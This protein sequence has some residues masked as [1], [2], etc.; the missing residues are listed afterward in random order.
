MQ[1]FIPLSMLLAPLLQGS[2]TV[3]YKEADAR[4]LKLFI[5]KPADWKPS[6]K[7]PAI[8]FYFGGGWVT[9]VFP[10]AGH[11][12]FNSRPRF[13]AT[14]IEADKSLASLSWLEGAPTLSPNR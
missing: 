13:T 6:D 1:R 4:E 12:F 7:R 5:E 3:A 8:V 11:G 14:L 2:E 9:R 10:M